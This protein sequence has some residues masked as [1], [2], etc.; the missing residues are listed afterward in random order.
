MGDRPFAQHV[1]KQQQND[2]AH[3]GQK[4]LCPDKDIGTVFEEMRHDRV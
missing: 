1:S 2:D 3:A 4:I